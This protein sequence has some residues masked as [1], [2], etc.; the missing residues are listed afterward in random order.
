[1][2]GRKKT[3]QRDLKG[4]FT[5]YD[6]SLFFV[7]LLIASSVLVL[8]VNY[9][10]ENEEPDYMSRNNCNSTFKAL[11]SS[12]IEETSYIDQERIIRRDLTVRKLL[13]EQIYLLREGIPLGNFSYDSDIREMIKNH[14]EGRHRWTLKVRYLDL[15]RTLSLNRTGTVLSTE[16]EQRSSDL[17]VSDIT[18]VGIDGRKV[19]LSY[20][21]F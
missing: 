13:L 18:T 11:L 12:T 8:Y 21:I 17:T 9:P 1:M 14:V 16:T 3:L 19:L 5:L 7:F 4:T 10:M 2:L 20:L 15:E 6:A